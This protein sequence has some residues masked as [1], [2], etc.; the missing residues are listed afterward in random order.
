MGWSHGNGIKVWAADSWFSKCIRQA[1]NHIC[2]HC[3][4]A[5][6]TDCAHI[7]G[8]RQFQLR[9]CKDNALALCRACHRHFEENPLDMAAFLESSFPGRKERLMVKR[10][11]ML[12]NNEQTRKLI[13]DHYRAQYR[14]MVDEGSR[15]FESWN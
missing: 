10:R 14:R 7:H 13:S 3:R 15:T 4:R 11:G 12:K 6:A 9:W 1:A 8:R 5:E 2:E